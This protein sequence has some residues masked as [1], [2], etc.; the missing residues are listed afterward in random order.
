M[1]TKKKSK[2]ERAEDEA[3]SNWMLLE[4]FAHQERLTYADFYMLGLVG[5]LP[6][7]E[8]SNGVPY[9]HRATL[10]DWRLLLEVHDFKFTREIVA[11]AMAEEAAA[12]R[13]KT[14]DRIAA[15]PA[16]S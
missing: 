6:R 9:V 16:G 15:E 7:I 5:L 10:I 2:A 13:I 12:A 8:V 1:A 3:H 11:E 4:A 14:A